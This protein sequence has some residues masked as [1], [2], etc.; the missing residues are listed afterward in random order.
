MLRPARYLC[1]LVPVL[2]PEVL[3]FDGFAVPCVMLK[4]DSVPRWSLSLSL[5]PNRL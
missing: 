1:L 3:P 2:E 5:S 4:V